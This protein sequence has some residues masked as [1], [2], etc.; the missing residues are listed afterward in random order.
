MLCMYKN[1]KSEKNIEIVKKLTVLLASFFS[2]SFS[3]IG[4]METWKY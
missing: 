1:Q 2:L 3:L 4:V